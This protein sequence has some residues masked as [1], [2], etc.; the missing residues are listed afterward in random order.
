MT[1]SPLNNTIENWFPESLDHDTRRNLLLIVMILSESFSCTY[2]AIRMN[3]LKQFGLFLV[4]I[5]TAVTI[6]LAGKNSLTRTSSTPGSQHLQ[7]LQLHKTKNDSGALTE[8]QMQ[9]IEKGVDGS[10]KI[11][12]YVLSMSYA[13]QQGAGLRGM[14]SLQCF[15]SNLGIP[16]YVVE[17]F[18]NSSRVGL[19]LSG[20]LNRALKFSDFF[21]LDHFNLASAMAKYVNLSTWEDFLNNAPNKTVVVQL[22]TRGLKQTKAI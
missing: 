15:A 2:S 21:D 7:P 20:D 4:V 13:G 10:H 18:I 19:T 11:G 12:T 22:K 14:V 3:K 17:P 9:L 16:V 8:N 6:Y 1:A 5:T